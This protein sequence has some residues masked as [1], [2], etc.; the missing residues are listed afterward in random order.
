MP[1]RIDFQVWRPVNAS[2]DSEYTYRLLAANSYAQI[3]PEMK[4][5][6]V[7]VPQDLQIMVQPG[8]VLGVYVEYLMIRTVPLDDVITFT[9]DDISGPRDIFST[10]AFETT[11]NNQRAPLIEVDVQ[12]GKICI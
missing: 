1:S 10:T 4:R 6:N 2:S 3:M 5:I 7:S 12:V 11:S 9:I 8:D